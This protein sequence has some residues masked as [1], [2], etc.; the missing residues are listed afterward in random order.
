MKGTY[1]KTTVSTYLQPS[2]NSV[3]TLQYLQR[4]LHRVTNTCDSMISSQII[5]N[6]EHIKIS[7]QLF[8]HNFD[9]NT[10]QAIYQPND[11]I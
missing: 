7:F 10:G 6:F 8:T 2:V 11:F 9:I 1:T 3:C 5:T 4:V